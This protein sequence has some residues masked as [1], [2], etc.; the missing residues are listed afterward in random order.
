M[1]L[2]ILIAENEVELSARLFRLVD[3]LPVFRSVVR[4]MDGT[5]ALNKIENQDFDILILNLD[6]P[7]R[8]ALDVLRIVKARLKDN[9][10]KIILI[11]EAFTK[12]SVEQGREYTTHFLAKPFNE[13][14]I[15]AKLG[16]LIQE[17]KMVA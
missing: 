14:S 11:S 2:S 9:H 15:K 16:Q 12:E 3:S 8:S 17:R 1:S 4:A 7:K 5:D 13:E 10:A 6:L